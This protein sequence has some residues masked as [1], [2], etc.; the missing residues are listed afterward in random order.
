M[1]G[2]RCIK[3]KSLCYNQ[4]SPQL[5]IIKYII[6]LV[7]LPLTCM[8]VSRPAVKSINFEGNKIYSAKKLRKLMGTKQCK[9]YKKRFLFQDILIKDLKAISDFYY[10]NGYL[11][12]H[13]IDLELDWSSDS[14]NVNIVI[15]LDD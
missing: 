7:L 2:L 5:K 9:F 8:S 10:R 15:T 14:S 1:K 3:N 13:V 6:I 11:D 4:W 12:A